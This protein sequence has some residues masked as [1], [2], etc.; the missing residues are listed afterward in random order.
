[1]TGCLPSS[2]T[3]R[4]AWGRRPNSSSRNLFHMTMLA[5]LIF[6]VQPDGD[7]GRDWFRDVI[8]ID[9]K[10]QRRRP[11]C[12]HLRLLGESRAKTEQYLDVPSPVSHTPKRRDGFRLAASAPR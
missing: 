12:S 3:P 7:L 9:L 4:A 5:A 2:A 1:M 10:G 11:G 6:V 8:S